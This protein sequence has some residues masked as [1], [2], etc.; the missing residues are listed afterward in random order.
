MYLYYAVLLPLIFQHLIEK[1]RIESNYRRVNG[2]HLNGF[3]L[4]RECFTL[5]SFSYFWFL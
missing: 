2:S 4:K 5:S 1:E 3:R